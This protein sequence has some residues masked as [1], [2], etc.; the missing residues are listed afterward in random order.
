M[1]TTNFLDKNSDGCSQLCAEPLPPSHLQIAVF[2][3]FFYGH[4][5]LSL[6]KFLVSE[7]ILPK[8]EG[9]ERTFARLK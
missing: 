5:I 4:Q 6:T 3:G 1:D 9:S 8:K 7:L 2:W